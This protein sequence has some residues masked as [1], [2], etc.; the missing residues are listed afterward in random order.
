MTEFT[1]TLADNGYIVEYDDGEFL[2]VY[3]DEKISK[4]MLEEILG[5]LVDDI[6]NGVASRFSVKVDITPLEAYKFS[7]KKNED[8]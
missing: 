7:Q 4:E 8:G 5:E 3:Q 1:I 6:N 2:S